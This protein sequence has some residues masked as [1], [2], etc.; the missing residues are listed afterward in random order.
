M[1]ETPVESKL[2]RLAP[3]W[4]RRILEWT[5]TPDGAVRVITDGPER[6]GTCREEHYLFVSREGAS[7]CWECDDRRQAAKAEAARAAVSVRNFSDST[8]SR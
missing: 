5:Y 4:R 6:C 1:T 3:S 8:L 7:C 2:M